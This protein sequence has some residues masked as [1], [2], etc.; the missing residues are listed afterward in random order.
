[1]NAP[2]GSVS[3]TS[4]WSSKNSSRSSSNIFLLCMLCPATVVVNS[5]QMGSATHNRQQIC[6]KYIGSWNICFVSQRLCF[7][8]KVENIHITNGSVL[9]SNEI[10]AT[11]QRKTT[12]CCARKLSCGQQRKTLTL[13]WLGKSTSVL[14]LTLSVQNHIRVP[15]WNWPLLQK[16]N[17]FL[18][19]FKKC[20]DLT[21][22]SCKLFWI[23]CH[24]F[25]S[26]TSRNEYNARLKTLKFLCYAKVLHTSTHHCSWFLGTLHLPSMHR[27]PIFLHRSTWCWLRLQWKLKTPNSFAKPARLLQ[28]NIFNL[29][30]THLLFHTS[31]HRKTSCL[32]IRILDKRSGSYLR[33]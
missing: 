13:D 21:D 9:P 23:K 2:V 20:P 8:H 17:R 12:F 6:S 5:V 16:N 11:K 33:A 1:M 22:S 3:V 26:I 30:H 19:C 31:S 18:I 32:H 29:V 4:I 15:P 27:L 28:A 7:W 24:L 14:T 25:S 10:C